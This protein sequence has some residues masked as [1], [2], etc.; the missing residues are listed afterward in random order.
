MEEEVTTAI[1][2][3]FCNYK[4]QNSNKIEVILASLAAQL[5]NQD[6]EAFRLL[7]EYYKELHHDHLSHKEPDTSRLLSL[8]IQMTCVF[9]RVFVTVD[10][11]EEC[12]EKTKEAVHSLKKLGQGGQ[13]VNL[14]L[15]SRDDTAI[16]EELADEYAHIQIT[17]HEADLALYVLKEMDNRKG[18]R[19]IVTTDSNL[20][21]FICRTLTQRAHGM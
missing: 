9:N 1:V 18:P 11:L 5:A 15:F 2:F 7:E 21:E 17:A 20:N 10:G 14:A 12:G 13:D 19:S 6:E 4:D 16:C 3:F 8:T